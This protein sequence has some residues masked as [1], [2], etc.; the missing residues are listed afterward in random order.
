M[1]Q[2]AFLRKTNVKGL[3]V[4]PIT[5]DYATYGYSYNISPSVKYGF[6]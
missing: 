3:R 2:I 6:F 5:S 1:K 4:H